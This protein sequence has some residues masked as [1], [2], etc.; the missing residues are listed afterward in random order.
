MYDQAHILKLLFY[1]LCLKNAVLCF[2]ILA[3]QIQCLFAIFALHWYT[4]LRPYTM[5]NTNKSILLRLYLVCGFYWHLIIDKTVVIRQLKLIK[6]RHTHYSLV[7]T[8]P[9]RIVKELECVHTFPAVLRTRPSFGQK[10]DHG[11]S[12]LYYGLRR[13]TPG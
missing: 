10:N 3:S 13:Y 6:V 1:N 2:T 12:R 4:C 5:V 8:V 11:L 7:Y 9:G